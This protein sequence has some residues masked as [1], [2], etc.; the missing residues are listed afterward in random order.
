M[1]NQNWKVAHNIL[2]KAFGPVGIR[3]MFPA[4]SD[5]AEQLVLKW[6]RFGQTNKIDVAH[7]FTK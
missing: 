4:M 7:E 6:E 5:I 2:A 1:L 3:D